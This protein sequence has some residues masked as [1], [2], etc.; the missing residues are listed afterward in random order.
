MLK[1]Q[2]KIKI[3]I[4]K[5][6]VIDVPVIKEL[7]DAYAKR[8]IMLSRPLSKLYS[9]LRDFYVC[10]NSSQTDKIFGC[11]A[12]H[13]VWEDLAEIKSL[14]VRE[15]YQGNRIGKSLVNSCLLEARDLGIK[16]VFA[17]TY[18]EK[19]FSSCGFI[20]IDREKLPHKIWAECIDCSKFP[21]CDEIAMVYKIK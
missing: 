1:K 15:E 21:N 2:T 6:N 10:E 3:T 16:T 9:N 19:F 17:L 13:I 12:L 11:S 14:C 20:R 4:R 5:A 18:A 7:I 8:G